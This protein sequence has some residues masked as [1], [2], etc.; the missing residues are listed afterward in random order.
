MNLNDHNN[1]MSNIDLILSDFD[2]QITQLKSI[3]PNPG[4]LDEFHDLFKRYLLIK[5]KKIDWDK[6]GPP[7]ERIFNYENL[8]NSENP[9][10]LLDRLA[11]LKLNGGLGTTMGLS[12]PKSAIEIRDNQN[13]IDM[14]AEQLNYLNKKYNTEVPLILMNS[15]NTDQE[16]AEMTKRYKNIK[17]FN[18]S[19]FIKIREDNLMPINEPGM[20]YPPGH[21]DL[22]YSL[23]KSGILDELINSGK[24]ILFVSNIDNLAATVDIKILETIIKENIDFCM[25][26]TNKTRAD[27][28]GGTLIEYEDRLKLLEVAMVPPE[29]IK[30]FRSIKK[31]RIFN[32]NNVWINLKQL[33][34][35]LP[36]LKLDIII[37][38]KIVNDK[39][40]I[41]LETA[42][43]SAIR[44]FDNS[45]GILV[46]RTRFS[47]VKTCSDLF[48]CLSNLFVNS[49]GSLVY[50]PDRISRRNPTLK[51]V[52][53]KFR[54]LKQFKK[55]FKTIP[56]II[57]LD[58]LIVFG[59][60]NFGKNI[61]LKGT[62]T[63]CAPKGSFIT[64]PDGAILEDQ[65]LYGNLSLTD[66]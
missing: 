12:G 19:Q 31:F 40:V 2:K 24:D 63:I 54:T 32:T 47:P 36:N 21:G 56:D 57:D 15:F 30:D 62:V 22:Y 7:K 45:A 39:N 18:Q 64:I 43:G 50:N 33:K 59:D 53:K 28:K 65:V 44:F 8:K 11:V 14:I 17:M 20:F 16:T 66:C 48:L 13:F 58:A 23:Q 38:K 5:D 37:N 35:V 61:I 10:K 42:I 51:L 1:K 41:Q 60:V 3:H 26:V 49:H 34:K 29:H 46:P 6:I 27:I 52:G 9:K 55:I 25:E 4:E